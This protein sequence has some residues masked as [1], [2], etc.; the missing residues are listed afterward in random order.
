VNTKANPYFPR[1]QHGGVAEKLSKI[2]ILSCSEQKRTES[3]NGEFAGA[4]GRERTRKSIFFDLH[5][6]P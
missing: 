5:Q 1:I 3:K 4:G 2:I 6:I